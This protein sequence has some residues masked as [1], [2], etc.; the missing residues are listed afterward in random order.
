MLVKIILAL[1]FAFAAFNSF[2]KCV[3]MLQLNSYQYHGYF[4]TIFRI[5]SYFIPYFF[6]CVFALPV[7][8]AIKNQ[9]LSL[10][11]MSVLFILFGAVRK[12]D[13]YAKKKLAYTKRVKRLL[14][15]CSLLIACACAGIFL[16]YSQTLQR[17]LP[18]VFYSLTAFIV[19]L[20]NIINTPIEKAIN[21]WYINDAVRL[22]K[23][24]GADII[25]ITGSYGK[26][27]V[28]FYLSALL[29]EK[30]DVLNTP[31]SF[32]TPLG[33]VR[34]VRSS[35]T[36]LNEIFVC[37]MGARHVHDIKEICDIVHPDCAVITSIGEQHL[38]TFH[39]FENIKKTKLELADAVE[40]KCK[41]KIFINSDSVKDAK[42]LPYTNIITYGTSTLR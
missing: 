1:S 24:S 27:S 12:P 3:H 20:A 23:E 16:I 11:I 34:T 33:I 40:N 13:K 30:Y 19:L 15:T 38:E 6:M 42:S 5:R 4:R 36:P 25:G 10:S 7:A 41:G 35:L 8:L 17:I 9:T 31:S 18:I 39:S 26:T 2:R 28:K 14:F 37:E 29:R 22:L 32:N 21:R